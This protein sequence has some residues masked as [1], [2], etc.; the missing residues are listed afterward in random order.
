M[1]WNFPIG[2]LIQLPTLPI[3]EKKW[4]E[5]NEFIL[6]L[7]LDDSKC[8]QTMLD[9]VLQ[10]ENDPSGDPPT[11]PNWKIPINCFIFYFGTLPFKSL[12]CSDSFQTVQWLKTDK[13]KEQAGAE[14]CQAQVQLG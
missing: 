11:H 7:I 14:L 13:Y 9:F 8:I 2:V 5:E 12:E 1:N 3:G 4:M 6:K 10:F